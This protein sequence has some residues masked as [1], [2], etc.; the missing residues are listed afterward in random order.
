MKTVALCGIA[1]VCASAAFAQTP[2]SPD[3][4]TAANAARTITLTG[5]VAGGSNTQPVTLANAMVVPAGQQAATSP[6]PVP[7]APSP[8]TTQPAGAAAGVGTAGTSAAGVGTA[9]TAAAGGGSPRAG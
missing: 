5:C 1:M 9:G 7:G 2:Q 4:Q 6:S 8:G 3:P